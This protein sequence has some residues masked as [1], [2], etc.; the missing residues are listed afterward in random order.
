MVKR[1][2]V[3]PRGRVHRVRCRFGVRTLALVALAVHEQLLLG[4]S[5][6]NEAKY[7]KNGDYFSSSTT[8]NA[9][10]TSTYGGFH[11][12]NVK[13]TKTRTTTAGERRR[14]SST[15]ISSRHTFNDGSKIPIPIDKELGCS[16]T[17]TVLFGG[18]VERINYQQS[19]DDD[20]DSLLYFDPLNLA[21]ESNFAYYREAEL[22]HGRV[23]MVSA[24]ACILQTVYKNKGMLLSSI[25]QR[26]QEDL[27]V[28][29]LVDSTTKA[30]TDAIEV[31]ATAQENA[32]MSFPTVVLSE[33][34]LVTKPSVVSLLSGWTL[35]DYIRMFLV[36]GYIELFVWVQQDPTDMPGDYQVGYFGVRNKGFHERSLISELENGR[37]AMLIMLYYLLSDGLDNYTGPL[38]RL[39]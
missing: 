37:L 27:T 1:A 34:L 26:P 12:V 31:T 23:C 32:F 11:R 25:L 30:T 13:T 21:T 33:I 7:D 38:L 15:S 17:L 20:A 29:N 39:E 16:P 18:L 19:R 24:V 22:K 8:V 5:N 2:R 36:C 35:T 10:T 14:K 9:F 4:C 6:H 3:A 28:A